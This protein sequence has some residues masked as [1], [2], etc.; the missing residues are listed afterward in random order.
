MTTQRERELRYL[1]AKAGGRVVRAE[2]R[3]T[4]RVERPGLELE[5]RDNPN[6]V[7]FL[8]GLARL[9][10]TY[11][12]FLTLG[13]KFVETQRRQNLT[14]LALACKVHDF[15]KTIL[16][17]QPE[18]EETFRSPAITLSMGAGDCDEHAVLLVTL[19][20]AS[21]LEAEC[22]GVSIRPGQGISHV[23]AT[24]EGYW[25]ETTIDARFGEHPIAAAK[26]LGILR[27][28]LGT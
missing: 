4:G 3:T 5:F 13:A 20:L 26:R 27:S 18:S 19:A 10:S 25:A 8:N 21:G 17:Y 11:E 1:V 23:C 24:A 16:R 15:C 2:T 9:D 7:Q 6:A 22:V 14:R 12:P 28:D